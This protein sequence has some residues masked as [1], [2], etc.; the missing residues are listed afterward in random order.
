MQSKKLAN[1]SLIT[2]LA[3]VTLVLFL[4][5][6]WVDLSSAGT[7]TPADPDIQRFFYIAGGTALV[8]LAASVVF[9]IAVQAQAR[10]EPPQSTGSEALLQIAE[11]A[12]DY[13]RGMYMLLW[14][15]GAYLIGFGFVL[16]PFGDNLGNA[17]QDIAPST[18]FS[19]WI[20][21]LLTGFWIATFVI[22]AAYLVRVRREWHRLS[23]PTWRESIG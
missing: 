18:F 5:I 14:V 3:A 6:L 15:I 10:Q 11:R 2:C 22:W 7:G 8:A 16:I 4:N 9:W 20:A 13:L 17:Y 19:Q 1:R 21:M 12:R 23:D